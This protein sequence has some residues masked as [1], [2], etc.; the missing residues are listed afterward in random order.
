VIRGCSMLS[1]RRQPA[2]DGNRIPTLHRSAPRKARGSLSSLGRLSAFLALPSLSVLGFSTLGCSSMAPESDS[3]QTVVL[4]GVQPSTEPDWD[5]V[6]DLDE[7]PP[8]NIPAQITYTF[9]FVDW[10]SDDAMEN[11]TVQVCNRLDAT[12]ARPLDAMVN[13]VDGQREVSVTFRGGQNVYFLLQA[14]DAIPAVLYFDGPMYSNQVGGRIQMQTLESI[15][16][17]AQQAQVQLDPMLGALAVRP[18][19]CAGRIVSGALYSVGD[20]TTSIPYTFVN[21][22]PRAPTPPVPASST[23]IPSDNTPWAGFVNVPPGGLTVVGR[24]AET[25]REFGTADIQVRPGFV[26]VV[27]VRALN[28]L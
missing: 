3:Y 14:M 8:E 26:H 5:C 10:I 1:V 21:G 19:D 28:H 23:V 24:L 17:L 15:T 18:H 20:T 4:R 9:P 27:E 6:G 12:C 13:V 16:G 22:L 2:V 11:R 25:D 7:P